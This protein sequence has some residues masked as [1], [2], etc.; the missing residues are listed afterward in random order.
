MS[1]LQV[2]ASAAASALLVFLLHHLYEH[3]KASMTVRRTPELAN[4]YAKK[5]QAILARDLARPRPAAPLAAYVSP[6]EKSM[7]VADLAQFAGG[8]GGA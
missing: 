8:L 6:D 7:L 5:F 2:L 3:F 1:A 4:A